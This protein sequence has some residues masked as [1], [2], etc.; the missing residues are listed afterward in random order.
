MLEGQHARVVLVELEAA[1]PPQV[2]LQLLLQLRGDPDLGFGLPESNLR[3]R[4]TLKPYI[5]QRTHDGDDLPQH[6]SSAFPFCLQLLCQR[7]S[8]A[9]HYTGIPGVALLP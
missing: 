1:F 3:L 7:H 5:R 8:L 2:L 9:K 6:V 4:S